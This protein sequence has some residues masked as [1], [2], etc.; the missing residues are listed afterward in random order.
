MVNNIW[1][2]HHLKPHR[3][4]RFTLARAPRFLGKLT[5]VVGLYLKSATAGLGAVRR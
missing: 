1:R 4:K 2:R 5:D 3:V